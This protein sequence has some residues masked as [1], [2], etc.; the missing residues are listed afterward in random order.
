MPISSLLRNNLRALLGLLRLFFNEVRVLWLSFRKR[1]EGQSGVLADL[2]F[3]T[4][5]CVQHRFGWGGDLKP[6]SLVRKGS[7]FSN[8]S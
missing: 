8:K 5:C 1:L 4:F 3:P 6:I 7:T 2:G